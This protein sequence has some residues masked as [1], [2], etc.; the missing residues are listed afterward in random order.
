MTLA[1]PPTLD[2][3]AL[4]A[5]LHRAGITAGDV[6]IVHSSMKSL[7]QVEGGPQAVIG[8]MQDVLSEHGTLLMPTFSHLQPDS[9]FRVDET[10]SRTGLITETFRTTPGVVRSWHPTHAV[11]A[12]GAHAAE[13]T[14]G[15][16]HNSGLGVGSPLHRAAE[17]GAKILMIGCDVRT[18]SLVHVAEAIVRV[19]YLGKVWYTGGD[20]T[21]YV[22][23][24]SGQQITIPPKDP[25]TCSAGFGRVQQRLEEAGQLGHHRI[26]AADCLLFRGMDALDAAVDL[27]KQDPHALLCTNPKC[28]VCPRARAV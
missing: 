6:L 5:A 12:W 3:R 16:E 7:G 8:A 28:S 11:S 2:R 19:P 18:C 25:P 13:W 4:R 1:S 24:P 17:A 9:I 23:T 20:R 14:A 22:I 27:L 10:P 26:G 15:H 21:L